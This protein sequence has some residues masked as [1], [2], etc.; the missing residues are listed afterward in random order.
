MIETQGSFV[1]VISGTSFAA[2]QIAGA[3]ALLAQAFPNL[4]SQQIVQLL[5]QSARDAGVVGDDGVYGQ[6]VLDIAR[7]FQPMGAPTLAGTATAVHLGS[8]LGMLGGFFFINPNGSAV[9]TLFGEYK[10]TVR[11]NGFY[12]VNPFFMPHKN[13]L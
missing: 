11:Q 3:V 8:A 13:C 10:G 7:A 12:W 9:M 5:Y 4:S 1:F 6:G 2:P